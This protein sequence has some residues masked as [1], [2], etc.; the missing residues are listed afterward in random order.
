VVHKGLHG[1]RWGLYTGWLAILQGSLAGRGACGRRQRQPCAWVASY[2]KWVARFPSPRYTGMAIA[3]AASVRPSR[4]TGNG[5]PHRD[6][7]RQRRG[8][9]QTSL[10]Y[11]SNILQYYRGG[12]PEG[13]IWSRGLLQLCQF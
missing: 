11:S 7:E 1:H 8:C 6:I 9:W 2:R 12:A 5:G 13:V 10:K 4:N 3:R